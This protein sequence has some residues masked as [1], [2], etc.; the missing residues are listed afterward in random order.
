MADATH[1]QPIYTA[2]DHEARSVS[3]RALDKIEAHEKFCEE[4]A[5][6]ADLFE[7]KTS[8]DLSTIG[9][10][11]HNGLGR[12]HERL[13]KDAKERN[14]HRISEAAATAKMQSKQQIIWAMGAFVMSIVGA[15]IVATVMKGAL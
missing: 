15:A 4:R 14:E 13:D 8:S 11:L 6:K 1:P 9:D 5:R 3:Q 7:T 2:V 12:L 10:K